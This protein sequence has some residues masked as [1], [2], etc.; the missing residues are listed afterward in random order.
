M[1]V[2]G[3]AS[4]GEDHMIRY[5]VYTRDPNFSQLGSFIQSWNLRYEAHLNRT[6]LWI[7]A[8]SP[9]ITELLLRF[10]SHQKITTDCATITI[11]D[12]SV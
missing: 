8:E 11:S 5:C 7:D 3:L 2:S 6:H 4:P 12:T 1:I 10:P 9:A